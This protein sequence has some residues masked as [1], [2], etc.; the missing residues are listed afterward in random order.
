M[1]QKPLTQRL[2]ERMYQGSFGGA[3]SMPGVPLPELET[4]RI[5]SFPT[6]R[7][8]SVGVPETI[9]SRLC[10]LQPESPQLQAQLAEMVAQLAPLLAEAEQLAQ[11]IEQENR[12]FLEA[13]HRE[14]RKQGRKQQA[15]CE[16]LRQEFNN[17]E[18]S[19]RNVAVEQENATSHVRAL[20]LMEQQNRHVGR[21]ATDNELSEWQE[22]VSKAKTR[23]IE[24]NQA[25]VE[26][27]QLRNDAQARLEPAEK[28]LARLGAEETRLRKTI[29]GEAYV[30]VETGLSVPARA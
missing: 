20:S 16:Q 14:V 19:L 13:Q 11:E 1:L 3:V 17:A 26:A 21:W 30:D 25:A 6:I 4:A 22:R 24:A 5:S 8:A 29:A 9:L 28:E 2:S 7:E 12:K 10:K 23:V 15:T 27:L 18:L